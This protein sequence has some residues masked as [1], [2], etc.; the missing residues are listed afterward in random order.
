[1]IIVYYYNNMATIGTK[2]SGHINGVAIR[3][4]STV[5][6]YTVN[7]SVMER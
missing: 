7:L 2:K 5:Q 6:K 3:Q 4:G 1:M